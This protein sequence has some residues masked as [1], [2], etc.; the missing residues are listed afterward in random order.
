VGFESGPVPLSEFLFPLVSSDG[1]GCCVGCCMP[2]DWLGVS[3]GKMLTQRFSPASCF[4]CF[5]ASESQR[6][7]LIQVHRHRK[8]FSQCG[9]GD[10]CF[11]EK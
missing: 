9:A 5:L 10:G 2:V 4:A 11:T 1:T 7:V 3:A 8:A 6:G